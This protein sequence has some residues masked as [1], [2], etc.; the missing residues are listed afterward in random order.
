MVGSVIY[1]PYRTVIAGRVRRGGLREGP[2]ITYLQSYACNVQYDSVMHDN[3]VVD[4]S[5]F[6][7]GA[8]FV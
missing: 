5:R 2:T 8:A 6:L 4:S 3:G 7:L 1:T